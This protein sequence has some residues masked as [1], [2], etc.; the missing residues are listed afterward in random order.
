[1][2]APRSPWCLLEQL[3]Q[4]C[5]HQLWN[6]HCILQEPKVFLPYAAQHLEHACER[7]TLWA[8]QRAMLSS[9]KFTHQE[10]EE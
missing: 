9:S 5:E 3:R 1:M 2:H 8:T 7:P 6:V 10:T 4:G